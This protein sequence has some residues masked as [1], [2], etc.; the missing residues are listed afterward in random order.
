[1]DQKISYILAARF[2]NLPKSME[3]A[4]YPQMARQSGVIAM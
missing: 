2:Q 3:D 4:I 1:M